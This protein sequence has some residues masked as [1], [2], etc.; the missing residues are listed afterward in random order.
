MQQKLK[1]GKL[2]P[3]LFLLLVV[4]LALGSLVWILFPNKDTAVQHYYADIYSEGKLIESIPLWQVS[5][6]YAQTIIT[7]NGG[8]NKLLI[9]P[10]K[11][12]VSNASCP[13]QICV[14]QG[15]IKDSTLPIVCLPNRLVLQLRNAEE[16]DTPLDTT[17][18]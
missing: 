12:C 15:F 1:S 2:L 13:D 9:S 3:G 16:Q 11:I 14:H 10:G 5:A 4:L 8:E 6:P 17:T 18:H 7:E